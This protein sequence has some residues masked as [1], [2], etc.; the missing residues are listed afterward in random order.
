MQARLNTANKAKA[1]KS[2][3]GTA[4]AA[5]KVDK[6]G[7]GVSRVNE[8]EVDKTRTGTGRVGIK[9]VEKLSISTSRA[10]VEKADK[11]NTSSGIGRVDVEKVD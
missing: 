4:D 9:D 5:D 11:L 3:I 6:L 10:D 1:E 8:E 7:I 2:G